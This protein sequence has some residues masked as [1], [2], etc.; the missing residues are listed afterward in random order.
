MEGIVISVNLNNNRGE[1]KYPQ[2]QITLKENH[3]VVGDGHAGNWHK[4]V[5]LVG[6]SSYNKLELKEGRK[7]KYGS[8]AENITTDNIILYELEIGTIIHI[9]ETTLKVS[10]IGK[11]IHPTNFKTMLPQEGIFGKVLKGGIIQ[12]G[13]LITI[14]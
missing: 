4:Q 3:G 9:G 11:K 13:D 12:S 8:F 10:Q 14:D 5:S 6:V 7:Y 2:N 1:I